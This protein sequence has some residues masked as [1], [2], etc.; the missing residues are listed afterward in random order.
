MRFE[1]DVLADLLTGPVLQA[2]TAT[3][4]VRVTRCLYKI[5]AVELSEA[6]PYPGLLAD[7]RPADRWNLQIHTAVASSP[8]ARKGCAGVHRARPFPEPE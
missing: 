5:A 2:L 6:K 7:A 8:P 1:V 3:P 4:E